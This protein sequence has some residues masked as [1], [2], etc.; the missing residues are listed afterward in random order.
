MLSSLSF[1]Q[2][3]RP[4]HALVLACLIAAVAG[5]A[6]PPAP[7]PPPKVDTPQKVD[8]H[9]LKNED[10][11]AAATA[12]MEKASQAHL[13]QRRELAT[14][15]RSLDRARKLTE[16]V[17][18]PPPPA[19]GADDKSSPL[20]AARKSTQ[21]AKDRRDALK[22]LHQRLSAEKKLL[23]ELAR[24]VEASRSAA[25]AFLGT[26]DELESYQQEIDLRV[27]DNTLKQEAIPAAL[28]GM[29]IGK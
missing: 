10:L 28:S 2:R 9:R 16:A 3:S 26:L 11:L 23:D 13:A 6:D 4:A 20:E 18:V 5:G 27:K 19:N 25:L 12:L 22:R 21:Q 15:E 17:Q 24:C 1:T 7:L 29:E 8:V 14:R